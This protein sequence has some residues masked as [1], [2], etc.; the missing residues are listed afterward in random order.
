MSSMDTKLHAT[1]RIYNYLG[2]CY[3]HP[4]GTILIGKSE[5]S[6]SSTLLVSMQKTEVAGKLLTNSSVMITLGK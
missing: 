2:N 3:L 5:Y 6:I 4:K 1:N